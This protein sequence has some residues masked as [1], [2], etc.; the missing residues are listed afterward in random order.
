MEKLLPKFKKIFS[1]LDLSAHL[2]YN[3]QIRWYIKLVILLQDNYVFKLYKKT[4]Y[5]Y[6]LRR[7][8]NAEKISFF[9]NRKTIK[10]WKF[11]FV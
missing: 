2:V 11:C 9:T 5:L 10:N 3:N 6:S 1:E 7:V 4:R 8:V